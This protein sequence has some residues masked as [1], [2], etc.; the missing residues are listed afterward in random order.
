MNSCKPIPLGARNTSMDKNI[1][2]TWPLLEVIRQQKDKVI[3]NLNYN[4]YAKF[5]MHPILETMY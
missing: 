2:I 5:S 3:L 1:C 4:C